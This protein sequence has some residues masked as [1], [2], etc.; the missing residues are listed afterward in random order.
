M[1]YKTYVFLLLSTAF[2]FPVGA[3]TFTVPQYTIGSGQTQNFNNIG[4]SSVNFQE[5]TQSI[6]VN[7]TTY[8]YTTLQ[9]TNPALD[10]VVTTDGLTDYTRYQEFTDTTAYILGG[11]I[12]NSGTVNINNVVFK[13][14]LNSGTVNRTSGIYYILYVY[15]GAIYND[16][17]GTVETL[18]ANFINNGVIGNT[19]DIDN[20]GAYYHPWAIA[21][22]GAIYN[23]GSIGNIAGNFINNYAL[24]ATSIY[25]TVR[26]GAISNSGSAGNITGNFINNYTESSVYAYGGAIYNDRDS[27]FGNITGSF[28]GNYALTDSATYGDAYGGAI[29]NSWSG[30]IGN[31][32]GDFIGNY[33]AANSISHPM[34]HAQGGAIFNSG[35]IGNITGNFVGN[36]IS[37]GADYYSGFSAG[38]AINNQGTINSIIGNFI[39]N[40]ISS[41]YQVSGGAIHNQGT[42]S[43]NIMGNFINNYAE[44]AF[45]AH[46]GAI[47]NWGTKNI[48]GNFIGN[49]ASSNY[50]TLGGAIYNW[51]TIGTINGSFINNYAITSPDLQHIITPGLALGGAIYTSNSLVFKSDGVD[52]F[53]TGNYTQDPTR[54]KISNAI[55]LASTS[56]K[57]LTFDVTNN[58]NFI[59]DDNIETARSVS[60]TTI[61]YSLQHNLHLIGDGSGKVFMRN[62]LVNF[63]EVNVNDTMLIFAQGAYGKG[64]F[65]PDGSLITPMSGN[66]SVTSLSLTNGQFYLY[67]RY[68]ETVN[69][70]NYTSAGNS[71]LHIDVGKDG[72]VWTSDVLNISGNINGQ[73]QVIVYA[74]TS[75]IDLTS[76]VFVD[77]P[78]DTIENRHAFEVFRTYGSP[79]VWEAHRN[80]NGNETGSVWYL[81]MNLGEDNEFTFL[82]DPIQPSEPP[83]LP[84]QPDPDPEP[85]IEVNP[86]VMAYRGLHIATLEQTRS[87]VYNVRN[88]VAA[89]KILPDPCANVIDEYQGNNVWVNPI[90]FTSTTKRP[91][92]VD[93]NIWGLEAGFD[94]QRDINHKLGIFA[95]YRKGDYDLSGK[96]KVY[97]SDIGSSIDIDSY[98]AGLYYRYDYRHLWAF[99]TLYGGIQQADIK[100]KDGVKASSDGKQFGGSAE[101][102]YTG[103]IKQDLHIEPSLG[104]FYTQVAFDDINDDFGKTARYGTISQI[105]LEAGVKLEQ[106]LNLDNGMA[107]V[108]VKPSVVQLITSGDN[109]T[110]TGLGRIST[111]DDRTLGRFEIGGRYAITNQLSTYGFANYTFGSNYDATSLGLGLNYAW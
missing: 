25:D 1:N 86:E 21:Q 32:T 3:Q 27:S 89:N 64:R 88:K 77:A 43:S 39:G 76:V 97:Y 106:Q 55:F 80:I 98:I 11:V 49:Y 17:T 54:N 24:S 48:T 91:V 81:T 85:E 7:G 45:Y 100:T 103:A 4:T 90:Y 109:V 60:G 14:N 79:F 36:H 26:G 52:S 56:T 37:T 12:A 33:A 87:M 44:G 23:E 74:L 99:A 111:Y 47:A 69:L 71:F 53:F 5:V 101:V 108:Y 46:G 102:G 59:I 96:G 22:G 16:S 83:H 70:V 67:N 94:V 19:T 41:D 104:I 82:P 51:G 34:I 92:E 68:F 50:D 73:T 13:D 78:N 8:T 42:I 107:K 61:D 72:G 38:G 105:E 62:D 84:G 75:D 9:K 18:V 110:I 57:E 93:T 20:Y 6:T 66:N 2:A 65:I 95:S 40:Y 29:Y 58:G 31:I 15:G 10:W 28:I 63:G 30:L 35:T